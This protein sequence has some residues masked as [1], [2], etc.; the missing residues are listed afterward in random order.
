[1]NK[2]IPRAGLEGSDHFLVVPDNRV[3]AF[4]LPASASVQ[5][6]FDGYDARTVTRTLKEYVNKTP[7]GG[8]RFPGLG[9]QRRAA[10]AT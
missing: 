2:T 10:G 3:N 4:P 1:M 9:R 8:Y 5:L 6:S 7:S